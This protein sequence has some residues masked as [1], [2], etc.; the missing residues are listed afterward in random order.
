MAFI[1]DYTTGTVALAANS[2]NLVGTGTAWVSAGIQSGDMFFKNGF[3]ALVDTVNSNTSITLRD[4]WGGGALAAGNTYSIKYAP[5]QS[6]VQA[7]TV[8]LIN[9][10][11][12]PQ[13]SAIGAMDISAS[14]RLLYTSAPN[15]IG[16]SVL[17]P[18]AMTLLDDVNAAAAY[19]T[20]G[21]TPETSLP[22]RLRTN[23]FAN[24]L[25]DC[26]LATESGWYA[27]LASA[28]NAPNAGAFG[29]LHSQRNSGGAAL[30]IAFQLA[31]TPTIFVRSLN[32][33][34]WTS[35]SKLYNATDVNG[36]VSGPYA[37]PTGALM[38]YGSNA[39]GEYARFAS[40]VQ[41]C[42]GTWV[43]NGGATVYPVAFSA[44]PKVVT[45]TA[46]VDPRFSNINSAGGLSQFAAQAYIVSSGTTG[47]S[48]VS[49]PYIAIGKWN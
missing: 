21:V 26:N 16:T 40:G 12:G 36:T 15:S 20:L 11:S 42:W 24:I 9:S 1:P 32:G 6:R 8:A 30:Q 2:K 37:G 5:D 13:F 7:S 47:P 43:V 10:L 46:L 33:G 27:T 45:E 3:V 17:T 49:G 44:V 29:I 25:A 48:S 38:E 22:T 23:G 19:A 4:N 41:M 18:W 31:T 39:N 28:V 34:V 35:W 14:G